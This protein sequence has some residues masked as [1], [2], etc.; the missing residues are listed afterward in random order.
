MEGGEES[1][2]A[3]FLQILE[4]HRKNCERQGKYVEAEVRVLLCSCEERKAEVEAEAE[5]EAELSVLL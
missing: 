2:V 4:E 5:A 3:D 1:A